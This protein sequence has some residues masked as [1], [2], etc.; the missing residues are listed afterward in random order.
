MVLIHN[1]PS[2]TC[3]VRKDRRIYRIPTMDAG[4]SLRVFAVLYPIMA[5][6][7]WKQTSTTN[8]RSCV[9]LTTSGEQPNARSISTFGPSLPPVSLC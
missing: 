4:R 5:R 7:F 1:G 9:E 3:L 8:A 6:C 2:D